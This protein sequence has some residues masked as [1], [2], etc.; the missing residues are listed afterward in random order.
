MTAV[1]HG[2]GSR[3]T[4]QLENNKDLNFYSLRNSKISLKN[5]IL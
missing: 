3:I 5:K 1:L 2:K 4:V